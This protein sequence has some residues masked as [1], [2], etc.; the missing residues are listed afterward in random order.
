M[1]KSVALSLLG[2][3]LGASMMSCSQVSTN[4]GACG[5]AGYYGDQAECQNSVSLGTCSSTTVQT[6]DK[7]LVCWQSSTSANQTG[8]TSTGTV[9]T[10]TGCDGQSPPWTMGAWTPSACTAGVTQR[11]RT[12]TCNYP[13]ACAGA[14]PSTTETCTPNMY[15]NTHYESQCTG[16]NGILLWIEGKRVCQFS[17]PA[18][19]ATCPS[20]WTQLYYGNIPYTI[21]TSATAQEHT[22]C[23]GGRRTVTTASHSSFVPAKSKESL[24][25]CSKRGCFGCQ[26]YSTV[27]SNVAHVACY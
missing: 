8:N 23:V 1:K 10:T 17:S 3:L 12:V 15:G 27:Y 22:N 11:T 5:K 6:A 13:C 25:Y 18:N 16:A 24:V 14:Q 21:T 7:N 26:S 19:A 4:S 2:I 9:T 20:G